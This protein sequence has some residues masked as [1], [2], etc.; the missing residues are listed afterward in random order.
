LKESFSERY[1]I[2]NSSLIEI[3]SSELHK[4]KILGDEERYQGLRLEAL[5]YYISAYFEFNKKTLLLTFLGKV[6]G[7]F[8]AFPKNKEEIY[9]CC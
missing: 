9:I 1:D 5:K 8:V 6:T 4:L 7:I 2:Y 3:I